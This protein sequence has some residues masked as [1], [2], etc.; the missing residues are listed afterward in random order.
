[1]DDCR[2]CSKGLIHSPTPWSIV[3]GLQQH[4]SIHQEDGLGTSRAPPCYKC[5]YIS[6]RIYKSIKQRKSFPEATASPITSIHR[7]HH[8]RTTVG[9]TLIRQRQVYFQPMSSSC[10]QA[11]IGLYLCTPLIIDQACLQH[12]KV[13]VPIRTKPW[14]MW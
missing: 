7:M 10:S 8:P 14:I 9:P 13:S 11:T 1:M 2:R 5:S 3:I 12:G 4:M 6:K